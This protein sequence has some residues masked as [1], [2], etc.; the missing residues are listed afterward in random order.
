MINQDVS[1]WSVQRAVD[2]V[3]L[4]T[5]IKVSK[6]QVSSIMKGKFRLSF[7]RVKRV[8]NAGNSERNLVLRSLY[9][10]KMLQI[11]EQGKHVVNIDESWIPETDFRRRRWATKGGHNSM[12]EKTMGHRVNMIVAVSSKGHVW[13][14][15]TQCN[16]DE[17]VMQMFLSYLCSA[18]G[19]KFGNSWREDIVFLMDGASYHRSAETRA[20]ITHLK[21]KVVISAPYSYAAA[22]AELWFAHFKK[23]D[24]NVGGVKTGKR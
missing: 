5:G 18:I 24:F 2:K 23:G 12:A 21:I 14:S 13:L 7:R 19:K 20:C 9:A 8:V 3:K 11:Y 4:L 22:P 6:R 10:Q 17:N 16:T 15:L 1:I